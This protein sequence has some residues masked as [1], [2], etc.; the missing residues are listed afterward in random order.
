MAI[1][2]EIVTPEKKAFSDQVED[3]Y[4][5]T[6]MGETGVLSGHTALVTPLE[7]GTLKYKINGEYKEIEIGEGFMEATQTTVTVLTA[8]AEVAA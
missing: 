1:Q 3:V 7:P 2:L 4:L 5:P 6:I 8:K